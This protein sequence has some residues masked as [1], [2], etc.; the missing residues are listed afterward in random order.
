MDLTYNEIKEQ[1]R[2]MQ[3][4]KSYLDGQMTEISKWIKMRR[5]TSLIVLGCGSSYSLAKSLA[6]MT[7][8]KTGFPATALPAGDVLLHAH[9]YIKSFEGALVL[10]V[11]RSGSTSE[12][13]L[14]LESLKSQNC[15]F[16]IVTLTCKEESA[17]AKLSDMNLDLPWAYDHSVCQTRTVSCLYYAFAYILANM[18]HDFD[19]LADLDEVI[20]HGDD[21]LDEVDALLKNYAAESWSQVVVLGDAELCGLAEEGALAFK[22]ICQ[23]PSNHYHLLDSRHGP[24]VL[25]NEDTMILAVLGPNN[26]YEKDF[27]LDM[28]KKTSHIIAFTDKPQES[29]SVRV[30]PYRRKISH[31]AKGLP[32]ILICQLL[33]YHKA[34][35]RGT[36]PDAPTGLDA[37]I[38]L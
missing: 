7:H 31:I 9:R 20:A 34:I 36:N 3:Q 8:M 33:S 29:D 4:T 13:L 30:L 32:F 22:E 10:A 1:Y 21:Y 5:Y 25:I 12:I 38:S 6:R 37:W 18:T 24:A 15:Q 28:S 23:L 16:T 17:L 35:Y 14:A 2:S 11:S 26:D 27:L 19:L